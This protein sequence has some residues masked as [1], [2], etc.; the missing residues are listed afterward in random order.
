M[1]WFVH[2]KHYLYQEKLLQK[3][4][5]HIKNG[6]GIYDDESAL[7]HIMTLELG[8]LPNYKECPYIICGEC[9]ML[10]EDAYSSRYL[11]PSQ[12]GI[13]YALLY[14]TSPFPK[15]VM[16]FW[17]VLDFT[18]WVTILLFV[19]HVTIHRP[20]ISHCNEIDQI[21]MA[22]QY[23][24]AISRSASYVTCT[25]I[26]WPW[27]WTFHLTNHER[28]PW[29][30]CNGWRVQAGNA[31]PSWHLVKFAFLDV[32][33]VERKEDIWPSPMTKALRPTEN[34]T[35]NGRKSHQNCDY[36][37]VV[38]RLRTVNWSISPNMP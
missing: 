29:S 5:F 12:Y 23:E 37:T 36:L 25:P 8:L 11:I 21:P 28:F 18:L 14:W 22:K 31:Y 34:S 4:R 26:I 35:T 30:V 13:A 1:V 17:T 32:H 15:L 19:F 10:I 3:D 38:D 9:C 7:N 20:C 27:N 16:I 2:T 33:I 6:V 24:V